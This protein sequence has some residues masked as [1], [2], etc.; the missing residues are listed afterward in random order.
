[1]Y[2][3][4][5]FKTWRT[6]YP[7][8]IS[9]ILVSTSLEILYKWEVSIEFCSWW[10]KIRKKS[11][12]RFSSFRAWEETR[13]RNIS[14]STGGIPVFVL[15]H[16]NF[17]FWTHL[18]SLAIYNSNIA[19][20][21]SLSSSPSLST[22]QQVRRQKSSIICCKARKCCWFDSVIRYLTHH[23]RALR[24]S[25]RIYQKNPS[26]RSAVWRYRHRQSS[27]TFRWEIWKSM[28]V[29]VLALWTTKSK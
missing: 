2:T 4:G 15:R 17:S 23:R 28:C 25:W 6:V 27:C 3:V 13:N 26:S 1:M 18:L 21:K 16:K 11:K 12:H 10:R 22:S 9:V 24:G 7:L 20:W 14:R 19:R 8:F 29:V 5:L